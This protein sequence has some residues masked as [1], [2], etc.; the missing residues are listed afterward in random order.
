MQSPKRN[1][2]Q[3]SSH[4]FKQIINQPI[5]KQHTC[6]SANKRKLTN[7][8]SHHTPHRPAFLQK[9]Q[10]TNYSFNPQQTCN[11]SINQQPTTIHQSL[12]ISHRTNRSAITRQSKTKRWLIRPEHQ[13]I[14]GTEQPASTNQP[15]ICKQQPATDTQH[16]KQPKHNTNTNQ[17]IDQKLSSQ[18]I[19][20]P[21]NN[22]PFNPS[23]SNK[24]TKHQPG[25]NHSSSN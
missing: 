5:I 10:P 1:N 19:N 13:T 16:P 6:L 8:S 20:H 24:T 9:G 4:Q 11:Q 23:S 15:T 22:R 18:P 21:T 17:S 12:N 7:T 14:R 25:I 3:S 2:R